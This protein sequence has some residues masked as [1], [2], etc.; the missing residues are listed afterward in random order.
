MTLELIPFDIELRLRQLELLDRI[1][2]I[3]LASNNLQ[4]LLRG[5]LDLTLEVFNADRA[6][7]LYPCDPDAPSWGVPMERYRPEWPG[8]YEQGVDFPMDSEV[9]GIF[10]E[11]LRANGTIQY[12]PDT[13]H[14]VPLILEQFS[15]KSQL[16]IA[17]RPKIGK[18][19][20]FGL[21]HCS[22]VVKHDEIELK[23]FVTI[24]FRIADA[25]SALI[26]VKQ[27]RESESH[28]QKLA[29][30]VIDQAGV[31]V[32]VLDKHGCIVRFN[33]AC[34]KLSGYAFDEVED[35]YLWDILLP[36]EDD[37]NIPRNAAEPLA[38][39]S[40]GM[41][42]QHTNFWLSKSGKR[43]LI[44]WSNTLL[45]DTNG[46]MEFM[47]CVG[48]DTTERKQVEDALRIS[49]LKYQLLFESS[50]DALS[51][52]L[53]LTGKFIDANQ[54]A[55]ELFGASSLAD[56]TTH[57]P[58]D[59]SPERQPDGR[60]SS[61]KAQEVIAI[62]MRE[63]SHFFEWEHQRL[64]GQPFASEVLLT[65]M[66]LE[67]QVLLQGTV[68]NISE[69]KQ[70]EHALAESMHKLEDKEL[71]KSRFLA[72]AGHD[73][74]QPLA[75]ANLFIDALK[76]SAL[77][78]QQKKTIQQLN[79]SMTTFDGLLDSLL[80][81]SKLDSGII[82]PNYAPIYLA[83]IFYWLEQSFA[84]MVSEK[85]LGFKLY[86]PTRETL[87][88]RSDFG[89]LKSL[90]MN[91]VSNAI[92]YTSKGA[93]FVSARRRGSDVLF[94]VWD[95]GIGI[96]S[97]QLKHIFDE[98]YQINNPQRD[99][100][101]GLGLGLAIVKRTITLLGGDIECRSQ[102]GR[103][104]VF[105][106]RLPLDRTPGSVVQQDVTVA[107]QE[108]VV[109]DSFAR[110]RHFIVVE[111]DALV[112]K[113]MTCWLEAMGGEVKCFNSAEDALLHANIEY[114]DYYIVDYMLGGTLNGIQ[115]LNLL[116]QKL[117]K[118]INAVLVTGDTTTNFIREVV[119]CDWP[120]I[121]KPFKIEKL[122]SSLKTLEGSHA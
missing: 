89:L 102:I 78:P 113:A 101:S 47:V 50:R 41:V 121:H 103:G 65:R 63:G 51:V 120:V 115:F 13:D 119:N 53:P 105:K 73:L 79:Q 32:V 108:D 77:T 28:L 116:R 109:N 21:H 95:T 16:M 57:G 62:A 83:D 93:I 6:W 74:R 66:E 80:N 110:G 30:S 54:S 14:P 8:L 75:A 85:H 71:S 1:T 9:A 94:Q 59:L 61:E 104:S 70:I 100:A 43:H 25:L 4:D 112:V 19:W 27:L 111:D 76:H 34:E 33:Q 86:F 69:R 5:S 3:S 56:F 84:L 68:R 81:I 44:E 107:P 36:P 22:S 17:L 48:I 23:L 40:N 46:N 92:K 12:G 49:T 52:V 29:D 35:Q 39:N 37:G 10:R 24:A 90:L 122:I 117:G 114:H 67:G 7:F 11:M 2:Q 91:L 72:A 55:L 97:D 20:L 58:V 45:F 88:V 31:L 99:R 118:P 87:V 106:F 64:D 60:L 18:A 15:V 96:N 82:K 38:Q 98:F 42:G 26:T